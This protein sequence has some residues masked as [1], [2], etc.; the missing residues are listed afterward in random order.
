MNNKQATILTDV[1]AIQ[2]N[3]EFVRQLAPNS[4]V[5]AVI[6]ANAYGHGAVAVA[7]ALSSA[8]ALAV[9]RVAEA[10]RLREAGV[11]GDI[12]IL[13]GA[14]NRE[15]LNLASI[16]ELQLVVHAEQQLDLL[17]EAG[18]RR[19]IWLKVDTG[20]GRLGFA[21]E[22]LSC[23]YEKLNGQR[24]VGLMT[25]FACADDPD[26]GAT[27]AQLSKLR[28]ASESLKAAHPGFR[29]LN[30]SNSAAIMAHSE[31]C[32]EWVRPGLMLYGA[33][34][35][36]DL[37]PDPNLAPAMHFSAPIIAVH[38]IKTGASVGYG[39]IWTATKDTRVAVV[40]AGYGDGYPR[41]IQPGTQ[42]LLGSE[43]REIVGRV[44]MDFICIRLEPDDIAPVGEH[45]M[46]WGPGLPI[47][48][49]ARS[50]RTIPYTLMCRIN[51]R[52][53]RVVMGDIR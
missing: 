8:S 53:R 17:A 38:D 29:V 13:S 40:A 25:H 2:H 23:V 42:V 28:V 44:S 19:K 52:V 33:S 22:Q 35:M 7:K 32:L 12:C 5:M 9:S 37:Q 18:A 31:T 34:P 51:E 36:M 46:L 11:S 1:S 26:S 43:R 15:D 3:F 41:E 45:V 50:A 39:G 6:K 27:K 20:M 48:E 16:Y 49:I 47:E 24:L 4:Q 30:T 14:T 10:V 21:P